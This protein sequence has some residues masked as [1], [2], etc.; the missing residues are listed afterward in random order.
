[1]RR[2][3]D[4]NLFSLL[5]LTMILLSNG[6]ATD[7]QNTNPLGFSEITEILKSVSTHPGKIEISTDNHSIGSNH[8]ITR[9]YK[10]NVSFDEV[11]DF[12]LQQLIGQ[13]WLFDEERE[14]KDKGRYKGERVLHFTRGEFVLSI[15]FAGE[16]KE[17]LGWDYAIRIAHP[18]EWKEKV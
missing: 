16:R 14:L 18:P 2:L 3:H 15:Q 9:K 5:L 17:V 1:M 7:K 4:V 8:S 13:G 10:S 11:K 6:C 12:Y